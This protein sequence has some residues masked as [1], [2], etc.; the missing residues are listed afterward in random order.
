ME[1]GQLSGGV[2]VPPLERA[3]I[4]ALPEGLQENLVERMRKLRKVEGAL[5]AA[6]HFLTLD[7]Y[8]KIL[9]IIGGA[10]LKSTQ[11]AYDIY[12]NGVNP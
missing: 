5:T 12:D 8:E 11:D 7:D 10:K 2:S 4:D 9:K 3:P 1:L 6:A